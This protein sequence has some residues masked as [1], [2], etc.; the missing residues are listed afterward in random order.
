MF[1]SGHHHDEP[2]HYMFLSSRYLWGVHLWALMFTPEISIAQ[3][4]V[5]VSHTSEVE[6]IAA[7]G[8]AV[9]QIDLED[10]AEAMPDP[11]SSR[12]VSFFRVPADSSS[13]ISVQHNLLGQTH[14]GLFNFHATAPSFLSVGFGF[15]ARLPAPRQFAGF[16]MRSLVCNSGQETNLSWRLLDGDGVVLATGNSPTVECDSGGQ[17]ISGFFGLQ[18]SAPFRM[19]E[20]FRVQGS[21]FVI[22]D[23]SI[24]PVDR[25]RTSGTIVMPADRLLANFDDVAIGTTG[26][27]TS[28]AIE[29][30]SPGSVSNQFTG[31]GND[32]LFGGRGSPPNLLISNFQFHVRSAI[33]VD[34]LAM[35]YRSVVSG[36]AVA[37]L[38]TIAAD[39]RQLQRLAFSV[40]DGLG[41]LGLRGLQPFRAA[42]VVGLEHP[43]GIGNMLVDN[44][45]LARISVFADGLEED[46]DAA[47]TQCAAV[48]DDV[49]ARELANK[50][51]SVSASNCIGWN[52]VEFASGP[53]LNAPGCSSPWTSL[54][55][56]VG[57]CG[58]R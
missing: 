25:V 21:A 27:F 34:S 45:E 47:C 50:L 43:G 56:S 4:I 52:R 49:A 35:V 31:L 12:G 29:L 37:N 44:V 39:G 38:E 17:A 7:A 55:V 2:G 18:S 48:A 46:T 53:M 42:N 1:H 3:N 58:R 22:D 11:L 8:G 33:D 30:N 28:G 51:R 24:A 9:R 6:F 16:S 36:P 20:F 13:P 32:F 26:T 14:F 15:G 19:V 41:R 57:T 54:R 10:V 40:A 5:V 23:L